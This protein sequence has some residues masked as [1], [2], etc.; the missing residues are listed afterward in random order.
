MKKLFLLTVLFS[1]LLITGCRP[2]DPA[3]LKVFV[4]SST[5]QLVNGAKVVVIGDQQSNPATL[6]FV[7]T[8]YTN[9]SGF[10]TVDMDQYFDTSGEENTTGYFDILVKSNNK[11]ATGYTRCRINTTSV[12]TIYLP[13]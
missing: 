3:I 12:E 11:E 6:E 10:T 8:S 1:A 13:N 5:N 9:S 7:D 2:K 4:R